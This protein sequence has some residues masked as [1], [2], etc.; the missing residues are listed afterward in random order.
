LASP[1]RRTVRCGAAKTDGQCGQNN[2]TSPITTLT[3]TAYSI[4]FTRL[5]GRGSAKR[6]FAID[7]AGAL[8]GWGLN[9]AYGM[10]GLGTTTLHY[11]FPTQITTS[12]PVAELAMGTQHTIAVFTDGTLWSW[13][14]NLY[15][16]LGYA[17]NPALSPTQVGTDT[18]WEKVAA[19]YYNSYAVKTNGTAWGCGDGGSYQLGN[20]NT[21]SYSVMTQIGTDTDWAA[22]H[23]PETAVILQKA[24]GSIYVAGNTSSVDFPISAGAFQTAMAGISNA[25]VTKT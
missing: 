8:W 7:N 24:N 13:G 3:R 11:T 5:F 9:D 1:L 23:A 19:S 20:G 22:I 10:L 17:T 14:R 15:G 21:S 25:F 18:S 16:Q 12:A 2:T 6:T 4:V